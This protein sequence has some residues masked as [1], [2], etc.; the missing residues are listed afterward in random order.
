MSIHDGVLASNDKH[1]LLNTPGSGG[2]PD[3]SSYPN[4]YRC[5]H[6]MAAEA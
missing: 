1:D 3:T 5:I 2:V 6:G 4:C